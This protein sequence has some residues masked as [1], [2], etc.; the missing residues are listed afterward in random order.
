MLQDILILQRREIDKRLKERYIEREVPA[1]IMDTDLVK[2]IM[3]PRRAGK[4][5]FG[6]H[7]MSRLGPFGYVNFDDEQ[8]VDLKDY[9]ALVAAVETVY[10][11]TRFLLFDEIQ[12]IPRWELLVNR[13]Q[14]Q[15]YNLT[16]TGSNAY[17][18]ASELATHLTGRHIPMY[19]T[20]FSFS[21]YLKSLDRELTSHEKAE[22]LRNY[23]ET[24]GY[25]E[26]V[27]KDIQAS[28]YLTT[29]LHSILYKDIVLRHRI[30]APQ[31][32][33]D[34]VSLLAS[35]V[36]Q[37]YSLRTL[38][39]ASRLRSVHT[40]EKYLRYL[41][42]AFLFFSLKRFSFKVREQAKSNRKIYCID[43]GLVTSTSF[44]F[45]G[46]TGR[47]YENLVA[48]ALLKKQLERTLECFYWQ[49]PKR[50]EVDFVVKEGTK[51]SSLIQ[52]CAN[53]E[54][55]KAK[56]REIRSLLEASRNLGCD[57]LLVLTENH[58][59]E[60]HHSWYGMEGTIRYIPLWKWLLA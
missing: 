18:L 55:P 22:V 51:V 8:L 60:K 29:L 59:G 17:L 37:P 19:I 12:N 52:V 2:V 48:V 42:E 32:L 41:E 56:T 24:G 7:A 23:A 57:N 3:G 33:E 50:E 21:E 16:V 39:D 6:I 44:R 40:V 4:S 34:M 30:R 46:K 49:G 53:P 28:Q 38:K 25:P 47:L 10:G 26:L 5:F 15:G 11:N 1:G 35:N 43:N 20:P 36:A 54:D 13:L 27:L 31:G 9:D 14:R 58:E 45:S